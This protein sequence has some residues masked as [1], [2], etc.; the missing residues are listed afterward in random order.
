V[1]RKTSIV[2]F[3]MLSL[4]AAPALSGCNDGQKQTDAEAPAA[5]KQAV[6]VAS[7]GVGQPAPDFTLA[8]LAGGDISLKDFRGKV[9]LVDFW[10]TWCGPCRMA[11]PH[12]QD[13]SVIYKDDLVVIAVSLDQEPLKVVPPYIKTTGLTFNVTVD[14]RAVEVAKAWGGVRSIPTTYLVDRQGKVVMM[15]VGV[16]PREV[17]EAE[18]RKVIAKP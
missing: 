10:A 9:V 11:M 6:A 5:G 1:T 4:I 2:M 18:I 12:F 7:F 15:W 17:Y 13:L 8:S 3:L 16:N 14:P